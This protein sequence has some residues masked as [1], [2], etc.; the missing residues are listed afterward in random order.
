MNRTT[1][2]VVTTGDHAARWIALFDNRILRR[3]DAAALFVL[4]AAAARTGVVAAH[5]GRVA[6]DRLD[7]RRGLRLAGGFV[8]L[9]VAGGHRDAL[10]GGLAQVLRD[11]VV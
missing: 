6:L 4:L 3:V 8:H 9:A 1:N 5:L 10:V 2:G 7:D 11:A